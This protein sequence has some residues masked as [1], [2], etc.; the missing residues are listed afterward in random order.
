MSR[1]VHTPLLY[2][3][4]VPA[5]GDFIRSNHAPALIQAVDRWMSR[6]IEALATD[7]RWPIVYDRAPPM[8]FAQLGARSPLGMAG[9]L[10]ASRDASGRR[11]PLLTAA[12]IEVDEPLAFFARSPLALARAWQQL[13]ATAMRIHGAQDAAP[14]LAEWSQTM[15]EVE[16]GV[17]AHDLAMRDFLELQ[18]IEGLEAM[19]R[20]AGHA[21]V[22]LR[23]LVLGLGLLLQPVLAQGLSR[24]DKGLALPLPGDALHRPLV[25]SLWLDLIGGFLARADFELAVFMPAASSDG[26]DGA[27]LRLGFEG[28]APRT[29]QAMLDPAVGADYFVDMR[30]ADWVEGVPGDHH[31]V[32]KLSSYLAQGHLSLAQASGTFKEVFLGT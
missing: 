30:N 4:K 7:V 11:F 1:I 19:L 10:V 13:E 2:F 21:E 20:D 9:C 8:R 26:Q 14:L 18:S 12:R 3:G 29:L 24:L 6:G 27:M 28:S 16:A 31:G 32:M 5:R 23:Q 22:N 15:V 17:A 25:A